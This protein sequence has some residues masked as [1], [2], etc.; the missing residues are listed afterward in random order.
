LGGIGRNHEAEARD[1]SSQKKASLEGN[2]IHHIENSK[3]AITTGNG[4]ITGD[5]IFSKSSATNIH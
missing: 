5:R 2:M 4:G 1:T 3:T